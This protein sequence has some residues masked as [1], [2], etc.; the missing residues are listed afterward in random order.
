MERG[1]R[2]RIP[3]LYLTYRLIQLILRSYTPPGRPS[4]SP[5]YLSL[6]LPLPVLLFAHLFSGLL[7]ASSS[8]SS[9]TLPRLD[10]S[11]LFLC[12]IRFGFTLHSSSL[13]SVDSII[14]HLF[15]LS[16]SAFLSASIRFTSCKSSAENVTESHP[17]PNRSNVF[18]SLQ[19]PSFF[20]RPPS[21]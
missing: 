7:F 2:H 14:S 6:G 8:R 20:P 3:F 5:S 9:R 12:T 11:P 16:L 1:E 21:S 18:A 13:S 15:L 17:P 19:R 4:F 10:S